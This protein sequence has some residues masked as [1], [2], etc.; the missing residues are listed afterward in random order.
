MANNLK[1]PTDPIEA[2]QKERLAQ[3][4]KLDKAVIREAEAKKK[5]IYVPKALKLAPKGPVQLDLTKLIPIVR[6]QTEREDMETFA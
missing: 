2:A 6:T 4:G 1:V 3:G 5:Q